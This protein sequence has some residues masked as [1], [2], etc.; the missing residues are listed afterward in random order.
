MA[1]TGQNSGPGMI[2]V[3]WWR[4]K[5]FWYLRLLTLN[6]C[7]SE[8]GTV[9]IL[10]SQRRRYGICIGETTKTVIYTSILVTECGGYSMYWWQNEE[11]TLYV[12]DTMI[13]K[14]QA[15]LF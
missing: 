8:E 14:V 11:G 12:G 4:F 5:I 13:L 6:I 1:G 7:Q 3:P 2:W 10:G 15:I 9:Y